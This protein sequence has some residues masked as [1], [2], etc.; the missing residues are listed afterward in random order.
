ADGRIYCTN[1]GG[2]V[3]ILSAADGRLLSKS[4]LQTAGPARGSVVALEGRILVR[5]ADR[6]YL[7]SGK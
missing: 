7:F 5:T 6:L 2:D 3:F 1:E 4:T